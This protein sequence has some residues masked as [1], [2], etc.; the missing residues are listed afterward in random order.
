VATRR[1]S[2]AFGKPLVGLVAAFVFVL[3]VLTTGSGSSPV[4][5]KAGAADVGIQKIKHVIL[6]MME[7]RSFDHYFGTFPGAAGIPMQN[8]VPTVCNPNKYTNKCD[9]PYVDHNDVMEG[10]PHASGTSK[11][12]INGGA[13]NGFVNTVIAVKADCIKRAVPNCGDGPATKND[14]MGY[15]VESDIP[16]YWAYAK[17][18]VLQDHMFESV[19]SW[20]S[21]AHLYMVSGWSAACANHSPSSCVND[22]SNPGPLPNNQDPTNVQ[23]YEGAPIYAWT[24]LTHL[25]FRQNVSWGYYVTPGTTPDCEDDLAISCIAVPQSP[26]TL[27]IW[28]PL[29][30]FDTVRTNGQVGNVQSISNFYSAAKAGTL[31]AVSWV[32]PSGDNSEHPPSTTGEGQAYVTSM[33]NA[34]MRGPNWS[35]TAIFV[36]WDDWGGF[37]DHVAPP[38]V[39]ANGYGIRV[40]ALVIS[41]Y[42]KRRFV[43]HQTLS[44]DAYLKFIED[45]FLN[46]RRIDP[47]TDGRWD[48]RPTVRENVSIL[49]DLRNDFDFTQVPRPPWLLPVY[50]QSTLIHRVPWQPIGVNVT[51][52]DGAATLTWSTPGSNGGLP[53]TGYSVTPVKDGVP[54][55]LKQVSAATHDLTLTG[56]TNGSV[57]RFEVKAINQ[58]GSS[59]PGRT[60]PS[61]VRI[62]APT[63]PRNVRATAGPNRAVVEWMYPESVNGSVGTGYVITP[64]TNVGTPPAA[65]TTGRYTSSTTFFGLVKGQQYWFTVQATNARGRGVPADTN[66]VTVT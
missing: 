24:D 34:V 4:V 31:P 2:T 64:H 25:L 30:Y 26:K 61:A 57:Y 53:I 28:N 18:Y 63:A 32:I 17:N 66:T 5:E 36:A 38:H 62:G 52:G 46:S 55:P 42:A 27:G 58:L 10:G 37:Y 54:Q 16:N 49:G 3:G 45:V 7:N 48:P 8:G 23:P 47:A 14:V 43:D 33:V 20:S 11:A 50:P 12:D 35:S 22:I 21:P 29:P 1:P 41:P 51:P 9:K 59:F 15:H 40:P 6:I 60:I 56:L 13:M 19:A 44:F 65:R 39:D